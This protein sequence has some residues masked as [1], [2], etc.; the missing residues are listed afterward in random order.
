MASTGSARTPSVSRKA[1]ARSSGRPPKTSRE[2]IVACAITILEKEPGVSVSLNRIAREIDISAM[3]IYNYFG[4]RDE[5][6]QAVVD[7]LIAGFSLPNEPGAPWQRKIVVWANAMRAHFKRHP[8]LIHLLNW[9]GH[10]SIEWVKHCLFVT[11][12][13]EE[14]GLRGD[15]LGRASLWVSRNV[16]SNIHVE[17]SALEENQPSAADMAALSAR[18]REKL[19]V[20]RQLTERD[21]YYEDSFRYAIERTLDA[22]AFEINRANLDWRPEPADAR[23]EQHPQSLQSP[24]AATG[25]VAAQS[26]ETIK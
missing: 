23:S 16:M 2:A 13:L 26:L 11:D 18:A 5:L 22:L 25:P 4:N 14:A 7:Q 3:S 9:E 17:L 10:T 15:A 20:L 8:Y 12:V 24:A 1:G 6:L 21:H 19:R